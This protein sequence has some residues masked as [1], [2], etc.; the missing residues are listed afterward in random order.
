MKEITFNTKRGVYGRVNVTLPLG[1]K[2]T[3][4]AWAKKSGM[5]KAEF[6][7]L[8]LTTGFLELSKSITT[9]DVNLLLCDAE[10]DP[11]SWDV[12]YLESGRAQDRPQ[13]SVRTDCALPDKGLS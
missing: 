10:R 7:R 13:T 8:A 11:S 12:Q 6:L 2:T 1:I 9:E 4:L 3:M 5:K